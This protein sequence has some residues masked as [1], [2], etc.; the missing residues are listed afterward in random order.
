MDNLNL[1]NKNNKI[2]NFNDVNELD[3]DI[4]FDDS[5]KDNT[6][7][8]NNLNKNKKNDKYL[9]LEEELKKNN[10]SDL[11]N[12]FSSFVKN[13][14]YNDIMIK[15]NRDD[16]NMKKQRE[17]EIRRRKSFESIIYGN[18]NKK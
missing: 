3:F 8:I 9:F 2:T 7:N 6:L 12:E 4:F 14:P 10:Y 5:S 18:K 16:I 15:L 1:F 17:W 13:I 11:D